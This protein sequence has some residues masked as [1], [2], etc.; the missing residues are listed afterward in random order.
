MNKKELIAKNKY[1][2]E[3]NIKLKKELEKL[4]DY[5]RGFNDAT[6]YLGGRK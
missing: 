1:L 3:E 5:Q 2:R 6:Y 4:K